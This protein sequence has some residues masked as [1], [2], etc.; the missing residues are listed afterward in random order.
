MGINKVDGINPVYNHRND[1]KG[2]YK[3]DEKNL[4]AI[5]GDSI[6][7]SK[8]AQAAQETA[9]IIETVKNS[10]PDIRQDR[11]QEVKEKMQKGHYD[12]PDN[13]I[14]DRVAEKIAQILL[15]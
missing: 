10:S 6:V 5:K 1:I 8:E 7:I 11:I 2:I 9:K 13:E 12:T 4:A 15:G 14:L 3:K